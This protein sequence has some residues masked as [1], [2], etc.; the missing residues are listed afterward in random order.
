MAID[1]YRVDRIQYNT[2]KP[3][4]EKYHYS[5]SV[6]GIKVSY[7]FGLFR[8]SEFL[9]E[10]VGAAIFGEPAMTNQASSWNPSNPDKV[11]ELR[12]LACIDDTPK[13]AESFFISKMLRWLKKNTDAE[14]IL[15]YADS[16][17]GHEGIIYKASNFELVGQT[18]EGVVL[19][20]DGK[21]YHDRTLRN[22][23]PYAK[24]IKERFAA[25][26]DN[27]ELVKT[28]PKNIFLYRLRE[29]ALL[30]EYKETFQKLAQ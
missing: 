28:L 29:S 9:P 19:M 16:N 23:K 11:L 18:A 10:L 6:N 25:G 4:I 1:S 15:S 27:I 21:K 7:C 17:Y 20:V 24:K 2:A 13:N 12:R 8:P 14:V 5:K 22:P 26:D 3:F 30:K